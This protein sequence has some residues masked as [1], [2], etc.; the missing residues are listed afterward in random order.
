MELRSYQREAVEKVVPLI[1]TEERMLISMP[2]GTGREITLAHILYEYYQQEK[3]FYQE[4]T[5]IVVDRLL[6]VEQLKATFEQVF[7]SQGLIKK[8]LQEFINEDFAPILITN[9]QALGRRYTEFKRDKFKTIIFYNCEKLGFNTESGLALK[10]GSYFETETQIGIDSRLV[11][12]PLYFGKPV[13]RYTM[14]EAVQDKILVPCYYT[15]FSPQNEITGLILKEEDLTDL[16]LQNEEALRQFITHLLSHIQKE[17]AIIFCKNGT[18]A[19]QLS[20]LIN[21]YTG[22]ETSNTLVGSNSEFLYNKMDEFRHGEELTILLNINRPEAGINL[23]QVKHVVFLRP[24]SENGLYNSISTFLTRIPGKE[25]LSVW[26]YADIW[27]TLKSL[28]ETD[29]LVVEDRPVVRS[30]SEEAIS[31]SDG[32]PIT[33]HHPLSFRNEKKLQG[34]IGVDDLSW[35]LADIVRRIPCEQGCMIGIFG[36]WGRGKTFLMDETWKILEKEGNI[37]RVDFQAWKYQ[38]TPAIWAY[39]YE[40]F[41]EKFYAPLNWREKQWCRML[42]NSRRHGLKPI[43]LFV[44]SLLWFLFFKFVVE[45][46]TKL[47]W[48]W[49]A[50]NALGLFTLVNLVVLVW[51]YLIPGYDLFRKYTKAPSFIHMLGSQVE[52]EKELKALIDLWIGRTK[53]DW[54]RQY[55]FCLSPDE[56][57]KEDEDQI[58]KGKNTTR[59]ENTEKRKEKIL[60]FVDDVD[61][62]PEEKVISIIDALR[63]ML[64]DKELAEKLVI[65]TAIDERI[66]KQ[67]IWWK[68]KRFAVHTKEI[69]FNIQ[70]QIPEYIDKLFISGIKLG[71]LTPAEINEFFDELIKKHHPEVEEKQEM[72]NQSKGVP[73]SGDSEREMEEEDDF[74]DDVGT[75]QTGEATHTGE[76]AEAAQTQTGK[77]VPAD[78]A[79]EL[80]DKESEDAYRLHPDEVR[81][82]REKLILHPSVTPRQIRVFYYRYL[83]AKNLLERQYQKSSRRNIWLTEQY[84]PDFIELL[85]LLTQ[86]KTQNTN[87]IETHKKAVISSPD[88]EVTIPGLPRDV[89]A[90]RVDCEFLFCV[91]DTVIGY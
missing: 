42:L 67:A 31:L 18:V 58:E 21:D 8:D 77:S 56:K 73:T 86:E 37:H 27:P 40:N 36:Q 46:D 61:R 4:K 53:W 22:A 5:L 63:I 57:K 23:P 75:E 68:Y 26:D 52:I 3:S 47:S 89:V 74:M 39:L 79:E 85:V 66:L 64:D 19:D 50:V 82:L 91:L 76:Q 60:L 14:T 45:L 20:Y 69:V 25:Y 84:L 65:V 44:L 72:K 83:I 2:R 1:G 51:R 9:I 16:S 38:E 7:P 10:V 71:Q 54:I 41:A 29:D 32:Q 55:I 33:G 17:K 24:F 49:W 70:E 6:L 30:S 48:A 59:E 13:Y 87:I 11:Q 62:C 15:G 90:K 43:V 80:A 81:I 78:S 12:S 35:E 34:V 28:T 88:A